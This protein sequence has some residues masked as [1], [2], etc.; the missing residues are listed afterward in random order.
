MKTPKQRASEVHRLDGR[1]EAG[2]TEGTGD[3]A[4]LPTAQPHCPGGHVAFS[5]LAMPHG[6]PC[7]SGS[8]GRRGWPGRCRSSSLL[9]PFTRASLAFSPR[10]FLSGHRTVAG[11]TTMWGRAV[12]GPRSRHA[13]VFVGC[14]RWSMTGRKPAPTAPLTAAAGKAHLLPPVFC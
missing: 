14:R 13:S 12:H 10:T 4:A 8:G 9:G 1:V 2:R 11:L 3:P 5:G 7:C 6:L